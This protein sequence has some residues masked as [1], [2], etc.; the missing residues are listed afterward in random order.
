MSKG[1]ETKSADGG[2]ILVRAQ[3]P[4]EVAEIRSIQQT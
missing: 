4:T 1:F 3:K 2:K